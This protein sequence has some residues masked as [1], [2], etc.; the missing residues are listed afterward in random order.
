MAGIKTGK[1]TSAEVPDAA[2]ASLNRA[3][4][5][6]FMWGMRYAGAGTRSVRAVCRRWERLTGGKYYNG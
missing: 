3:G 6:E 2:L 1:R 4:I 5:W